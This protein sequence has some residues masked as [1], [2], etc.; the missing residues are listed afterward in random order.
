VGG[1]GIGIADYSNVPPHLGFDVFIASLAPDANGKVL[2]NNRLGGTDTLINIKG[3][4][5][6]HGADSLT[7]GAGDEYFRGNGGDDTIDG[8]AG[9]DWV[10]YSN[11]RSRAAPIRRCSLSMR[12]QA[13]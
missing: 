9:N 13:P 1:A 10:F 3:L 4:A 2:V 11:M 7:G 5:G 8:G 12:R 6:T